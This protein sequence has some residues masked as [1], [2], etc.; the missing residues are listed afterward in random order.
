MPAVCRH[1]D[2]PSARSQ[3]QNCAEYS[4]E[5]GFAQRAEGHEPYCT[6]DAAESGQYLEAIGPDNRKVECGGDV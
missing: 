3:W 6:C 1:P 4:Y 5:K 2:L